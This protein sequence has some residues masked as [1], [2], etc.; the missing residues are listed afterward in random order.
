MDRGGY[1]QKINVCCG[2][3]GRHIIDSFFIKGNLT[4]D[5]Y[6]QLLQQSFIPLLGQIYPNYGK[7]YLPAESILFQQDGAHPHFG[8]QVR[9]Y[10]NETFPGS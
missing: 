9:H 4:S 1:S 5:K 3:I 8:H 7:A 6:L 10:L 2:F